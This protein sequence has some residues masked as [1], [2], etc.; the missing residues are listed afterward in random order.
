MCTTILLVSYK[1]RWEILPRKEVVRLKN[2][3]K[4][5]R[6]MPFTFPVLST[7]EDRRKSH[8]SSVPSLRF[9]FRK[10]GYKSLN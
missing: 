4:P 8:V 6:L 9:F 7:R 10:M 5:W 1:V 3:L 2:G